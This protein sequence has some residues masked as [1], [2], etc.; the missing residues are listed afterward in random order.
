[1]FQ[2]GVVGALK[3]VLVMTLQ[4]RGGR[5][6]GG[7]PGDLHAATQA[8]YSAN[9]GNVSSLLQLAVDSAR[10]CLSMLTHAL[11]WLPVQR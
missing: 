1:M 4:R 3:L 2:N 5:C 11:Q 8:S 10:T 6:G 9:V 7:C